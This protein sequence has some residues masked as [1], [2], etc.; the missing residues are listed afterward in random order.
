MVFALRT[1]HAPVNPI[2]YLAGQSIKLEAALT[3][4]EVQIT[5]LLKKS[6]ISQYQ[7]KAH[8]LALQQTEVSQLRNAVDRIDPSLNVE[9]S[10]VNFH[11]NKIVGE[12]V[13]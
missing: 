10:F 9:E 2:P 5:D 6:L 11:W 7:A 13:R 1:L 4:E 12:E 3:T 8:T